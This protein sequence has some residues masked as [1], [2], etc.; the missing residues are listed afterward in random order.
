MAGS[1]FMIWA[2]FLG[3]KDSLHSLTGLDEDKNLA[4]VWQAKFVERLSGNPG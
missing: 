1:Q 2:A 3:I 4:A